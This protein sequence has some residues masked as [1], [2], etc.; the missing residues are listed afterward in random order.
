MKLLAICSSN[1][2]VNAHSHEPQGH[3]HNRNYQHLPVQCH[4]FSDLQFL[5]LSV[6]QS[7]GHLQMLKMSAARA[8]KTDD[9]L[10]IAERLRRS[11]QPL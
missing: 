10:T 6:G 11:S 8:I 9:L 1:I 2:W 3:S 5:A 7:K 4:A